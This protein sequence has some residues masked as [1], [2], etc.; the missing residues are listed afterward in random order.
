MA[1]FGNIAAALTLGLLA[2]AAWADLAT[3]TIPDSVSVVLVLVGLVA[4]W[5]AGIGGIAASLGTALVLFAILVFLH[6][7]GMIGGGDVKL[8]AAVTAGLSLQA[9][10]R[11]VVATTL[12][13]GVLSLLHLVLRRVLR[14]YAPVPPPRRGAPVLQRIFAAE[15]WRIARHGSL[16]YAVA[17]GCGGIYAILSGPGG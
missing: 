9:A 4:R 1:L 17:I 13:G 12:A 3:R 14:D 2:Y 6:A 15:R 10:Y 5:P 16:P 7:R 11:F 8:A